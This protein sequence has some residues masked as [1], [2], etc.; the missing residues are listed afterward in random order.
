MCVGQVALS[1]L[2]EQQAQSAREQVDG[3]TRSELE[4][5][6]GEEDQSECAPVNVAIA[7]SLGADPLGDFYRTKVSVHH[8]PLP[9]TVGGDALTSQRV[10][11][12]PLFVTETHSAR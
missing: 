3:E 8:Q 5:E 1:R 7:C 11:N 6:G 10:H 12:L 4:A 2:V 9:L